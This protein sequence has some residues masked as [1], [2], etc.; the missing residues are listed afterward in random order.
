MLNF[1]TRYLVPC[2]SVLTGVAGAVPSG[3]LK[4]F[5]QLTDVPDGWYR[6]VPAPA[7]ARLKL[8]IAIRQD[9][10]H[11]FLQEQL[12]RISDP[13]HELYGQ[14]YDAHELN[15][16]LRPEPA[17]SSA[18][19]S[20]LEQQG[21]P[22]VEIEDNGDW[23]S[24]DTTVTRAENLLDTTFYFFHH[25]E[26]KSWRIR[27]L[28]YSIPDRLHPYVR[29]IQPTTHFARSRANQQPGPTSSSIPVYGSATKLNATYCNTTT[30]A[31]C[32]RALYGIGDF[33]ANASSGSRLGIP[34]FAS[35]NVLRGDLALFVDK[36][37]PYARGANLSITSVNGG[38]NNGSTD[39]I[40]AS[41]ANM[42]V[43]YGLTLAYPTPVDFYK[44][45]GRGP[46]IHDLQLPDIP[47]ALN[48]QEPFLEYLQ[49]MVNLTHDKLPQVISISYGEDEQTHPLSYMLSVCQLFAK[50]GARGVSVI[51]SSG[52]GGPGD[53]CMTNDGQNR[54]RFMPQFPAS[55]P[56]VTSVGGTGQVL[57]EI[58]ERLSGGGFSDVFARP[59]Y[60]R[61]Q[62]ETYLNG[63][64]KDKFQGLYNATGRGIPDVA[65]QAWTTFP[66]F[67]LG[68]EQLSGGTSVATPTWAAII[69]NL[70]SVRLS[71]GQKPLGFL[72]PW[73]YKTA[74]KALT[75]IT[76]G[77]SRGCDNVTNAGQDA[78]GV[79]GAGWKAVKGW[80]AVTGLGTPNL[81]KLLDLAVEM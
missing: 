30:S 81:T 18:V 28:E 53:G 57:P 13:E 42:D 36:W 1:F 24:V 19:L 26:D 71:R 46:L 40:W 55:C 41:E 73:L 60:Q 62:V 80:D 38:V 72:N 8:H 14:H 63:T 39:A 5:E 56:W 67:H 48:E 11:A 68:R 15:A 77:S 44:V 61:A 54:T 64:V 23:I 35:Q 59:D 12:L 7:L 10:K 6:G 9:D 58:A 20:W 34:A 43:Q 21:I 70:N 52:N 45:G 37:A 49:Y 50:L 27:T 76:Q 79:P 3:Q 2:A 25:A 33:R 69:A 74:Y 31:D 78:P 47:G 29:M 66:I 32:I 65:A 16:L 75:D 22:A 51:T 17:T 4:V